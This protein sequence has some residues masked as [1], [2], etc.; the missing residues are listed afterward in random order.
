[1]K[2]NNKG[3]T[4]VEMIVVTA[5]FIVIIVITGD[6]FNTVLTQSSKLYK[7]EESNIEGIIGLEMFRHDLE[8]GGFG[9]PYSYDAVTP[10]SYMEAGYAPANLYNDASTP[11]KVPRA[12]V[13]G[14]IL[15]AVADPNS[16]AGVSYNV[17]ANT[18]YLA[19]KATSVGANNASQKWTYLTY[20]S[21]GKPPKVWPG[22][23][24]KH[25]V[26]N[27]IMLRRTYKDTG[28]D[29]QLVYATNKNP[30]DVYWQTY[31]SSGFVAAYSPALPTDIFYLYGINSTNDVGM[32]F[33][34]VDYFVAKPSDTTRI[35]ATCSSD[36]G[37]LY[38]A[39]VNHK[40]TTPGG[41]LDYMPILDCVADM[42]VVFG[43]SLADTGGTVLV[44]ALNSTA[45]N[46]VL[47]SGLVDTWSN[48]NGSQVSSSV[49]ATVSQVQTAMADPGHV[50]TKLKVVKVYILAQNG[51]KDLSY[52]S[53][54]S[55][56]IGDPGEATLTKPGGFPVTAAMR[57]YRWKVYRLVIK[58]KNLISN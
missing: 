53:P 1:M 13:A 20:S 56:L 54:G 38:R 23:N 44:D 17:L 2:L 49:A 18:D 32:P 37:I 27:I 10:I 55:I 19:I 45:N 22:G 34:R 7:S 47:G 26:D 25:L 36:A 14:V 51:R 35:P 12:F 30:Q 31:N 48:A 11:S 52:T 24:L 46:T 4:L 8:Q 16:Y 39:G 15:G 33:N 40:S 58:P 5:L 41:T 29:N 42:Q 43:W 50:R 57:N 6:A 9:L 21:S 3:F 28:Y